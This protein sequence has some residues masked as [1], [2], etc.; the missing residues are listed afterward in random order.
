MAEW[1][2]VA[3]RRCAHSRTSGRLLGASWEPFGCF[4]GPLL[5]LLGPSWG[6]LK[7][8]LPVSWTIFPRSPFLHNP[9]RFF[10]DFRFHV[11]LKITRRR[12]K[13]GPNRHQNGPKNAKNPPKAAQRAKKRAEDNPR[14]PQVRP[15]TAQDGPLGGAP[16]PSWTLLGNLGTILDA[17]EPSWGLLGASWDPFGCFLEPLLILLE[18]SWSL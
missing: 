11:T 6:L 14:E 16:D 18:P 8:V 5:G 4:L 10:A 3:S 7:L 1:T 13:Q 12:S 9:P 15:K 17:P 2:R